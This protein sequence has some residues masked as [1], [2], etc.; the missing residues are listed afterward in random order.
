MSRVP[1]FAVGGTI[2]I[3]V[4]NQVG[5][6]T[7]PKSGR[8]TLYCTDLGKAFDIPIF[9]C[10]GDDP[11]SVVTAFEM[12]VEWRQKVRFDTLI[13]Y[14]I[15]ITIVFIYVILYVYDIYVIVRRGLHHRHG[16]L[17]PLRPQRARPAYV[18]PA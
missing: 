13:L 8:S 4:N 9:H 11:L 17:P 16:L 18:H 14:C 3:I 10:N 1:D 12:A 2:H 15:I 5:F 6:T 7:D